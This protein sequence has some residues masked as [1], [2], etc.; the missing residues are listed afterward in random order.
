M[1][2]PL[3]LIPRLELTMGQMTPDGVRW[4]DGRINTAELDAMLSDL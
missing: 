3:D 1:T 4:M 2:H